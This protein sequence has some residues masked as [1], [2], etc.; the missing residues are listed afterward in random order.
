MIKNDEKMG[1][2]INLNP[3]LNNQENK[4]ETKLKFNESMNDHESS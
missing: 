1:N 3:P 4:N 2:L